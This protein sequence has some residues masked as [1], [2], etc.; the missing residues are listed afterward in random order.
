LSSMLLSSSGTTTT[1]KVCDCKS[2]MCTENGPPFPVLSCAVEMVVGPSSTEK[3]HRARLYHRHHHWLLLER[4]W[5]CV[6]VLV[7]VSMRAEEPEPEMQDGQN[8]GCFLFETQK[9]RQLEPQ[10]PRLCPEGESSNSDMCK[11]RR[12]S[13][14]E[15]P[16]ETR[17]GTSPR[18]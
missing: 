2:E 10:S 13:W 17:E 4:R 1:L 18:D 9:H 7:R 8:S 5:R 12:K 3:V 6:E 11:P 14:A 15:A 16:S